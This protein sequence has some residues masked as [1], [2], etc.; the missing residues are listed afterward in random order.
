[1]L[2]DD[3]YTRVMEVIDSLRGSSDDIL[4]KFDEVVEEGFITQEEWRKN[5]SDILAVVDNNIFMCVTCGWTLN[6]DEMGEDTD[7]GELQCDS[8]DGSGKGRGY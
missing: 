5:E 1:M 7:G 3:L 4:G 2:S 8:C 6:V